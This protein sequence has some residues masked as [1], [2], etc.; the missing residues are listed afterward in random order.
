MTG[1]PAFVEAPRLGKSVPETRRLYGRSS[2]AVGSAQSEMC[3]S[4]CG[5]M[6]HDCVCVCARVCVCVCAAG[7]GVYTRVGVK[8]LSA[9]GCRGLGACS[10]G[11][12]WR[13]TTETLAQE[14]AFCT[15]FISVVGA[16]LKGRMQGR[17]N[18]GRRPGSED[19]CNVQSRRAAGQV[20]C[21]RLQGR[22]CGALPG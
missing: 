15:G 6:L 20:E 22:D 3:V 19:G 18:Q 13:A 2:D 5:R 10:P 8:C 14:A 9:T 11:H 21:S 4:V 16:A 1:R 17:G 12:P 7:V